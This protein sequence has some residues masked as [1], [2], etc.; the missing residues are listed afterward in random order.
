VV[1]VANII[2][3]Q[4]GKKITKRIRLFLS[5]DPLKTMEG[6]ITIPGQKARLSDVVNDEREFL[7]LSKVLVSE[8]WIDPLG[9]FVLLNK[10]EVKAIV[11]ID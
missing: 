3:D 6:T 4:S 10:R 8:N 1:V 7:S 2:D 11:E 9:D 5:F